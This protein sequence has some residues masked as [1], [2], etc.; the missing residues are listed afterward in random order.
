MAP[1]S[2]A[3]LEDYVTHYDGNIFSARQLRLM[4]TLALSGMA[5]GVVDLYDCD[6]IH[7]RCAVGIMIDSDHRRRGYGAQAV[8]LMAVYCRKHLGLRQLYCIV[9]ND[10]PA[11]LGLFAKAGFEVSGHLRSWLRRESEW[12]DAS[13]LQLLL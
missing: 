13:L 11:S 2:R 10:N 5:V 4:V 6:F 7:Q 8:G 3:Q 12:V 9:G 1:Y